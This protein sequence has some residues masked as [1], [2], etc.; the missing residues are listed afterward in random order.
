MVRK[1]VFDISHLVTRLNQAATTGIDR[2]DLAYA[3]HLIRGRLRAD[4]AIQ[5][6]LFSPH[7]LSAG[8]MRSLVDLFEHHQFEHDSSN[9]PEMLA[10]GPRTTGQAAER[11]ERPPQFGPIARARRFI[12]QS[13]YR[14]FHDVG[15]TVP[16]DAIY[17]NVA[18]HAFEHH[19]FFRWLDNR[20]DILPV[21][22]I[23]D[24][25]PLDFPE[26]FPPGYQQRF[27]RRV[28]TMIARARAIITTSQE[29]A[30]R[31]R[32]EYRERDLVPVPIHI[33]ALASPL[34]WTPSLGDH[35]GVFG[36]TPFFLLVSK[37][38]PRKNHPLLI[39]VWRSLIQRSDSP[40]KLILVGQR[41][42]E[43]AQTL[44]ELDLAPD[45]QPHIVQVPSLPSGQLRAL[46]QR[47]VA[48][49]MPS[50]A[51]GY[52]IP[53]VEALSLGTPVICSDIPVFGEISQGKA[54]LRAP[55]DGQ[56]WLE[57]IE[58]MAGADSIFRETWARKA[59]EFRAPT[60]DNYF[61]NVHNFLVTLNDM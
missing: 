55:L 12:S 19:R 30:E 17:L 21:F 49:L 37:I 5:Y 42:W 3:R 48:V 10:L 38:E 15:A 39:D 23:H 2:V 44:R 20:P 46:M 57:A 58:M 11:P 24:L 61:D 52:G 14:I 18:Q 40:P 4:A 8:R 41:G 1:I 50:F 53:I 34:E 32:I 26:F 9:P 27:E 25:L 22:L 35:G 60:W 43:S 28:E 51:E 56:G 31:I 33:E 45:L 36:D 59:R 13:S 16:R 7:V 6:G 47:A 54:L 29:V